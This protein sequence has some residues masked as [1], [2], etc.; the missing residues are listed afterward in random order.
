MME[1]PTKPSF[2]VRNHVI[3]E[4]KVYRKQVDALECLLVFLVQQFNGTAPVPMSSMGQG[5]KRPTK[6]GTA[7]ALVLPPSPSHLA[8]GI[9]P[10]GSLSYFLA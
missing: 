8:G 9:S 1:A 7:P 3:C 2:M 6:A 10:V 4:N 5:T